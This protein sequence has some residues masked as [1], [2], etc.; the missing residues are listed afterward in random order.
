MKFN[1]TQIITGI[2]FIHMAFFTI[3][4]AAELYNRANPHHI[5]KVETVA[6]DPRDLLSGQYIRLRYPF[7]RL[8]EGQGWKNQK[9][10]AWAHGFTKECITSGTGY[11][12]FEKDKNSGLHK[13]AHTLCGEEVLNISES[14][15]ALRIMTMPRSIRK[16]IPRGE[17]GF[18]MDRFY[19]PE[20]TPEPSTQ[21]ILTVEVGI[22]KSGTGRVRNVYLRGEPLI[23]N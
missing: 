6:Y 7:Q 3:W 8:T 21:E 11:I 10:K 17:F 5:I 14:S 19:V 18:G 13:P 16:G 15:P 9:P 22:S 20:G 23:R 2:A 1:R 4:Y 12:V